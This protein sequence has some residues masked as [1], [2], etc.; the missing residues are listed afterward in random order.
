MR[1]IGGTL[2]IKFLM[3]L[4]GMKNINCIK[5]LRK[6]LE[7]FWKK[8]KDFPRLVDYGAAILTRKNNHL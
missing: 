8:N 7:S 5:K 2:A 4:I 3:V 6:Q 1:G